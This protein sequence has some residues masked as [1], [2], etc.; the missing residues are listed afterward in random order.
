MVMSNWG[1]GDTEHDNEQY[2]DS[3]NKNLAD[4]VQLS[5]GKTDEKDKF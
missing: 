4:S 3:T 1:D 5:Q 2:D